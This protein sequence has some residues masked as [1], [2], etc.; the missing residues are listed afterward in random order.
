MQLYIAKGT[1]SIAAA[2]VLEEAGLAY[3]AIV[4]DFAT[5]AQT[6]PDYMAVNP[7][8]RVPALTVPDGILTETGAILEYIATLAPAAGLAP[9]DALNAARMRE[10]MYYIAST[11]HVN[12]AHKLRG[13]RWADLPESHADMRAKVAQTMAASCTYL[14]ENVAFSPFVLGPH[15]SL[16]DAYLYVACTWLE[17]DNVDIAAYPRLAAHF[18]AMGARPSVKKLRAYDWI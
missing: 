8:G 4:L 5:A 2:L 6:K 10:V 14:E 9:A 1:I 18:A 3:D 16:A 7:K 15:I 17:G 13:T 12:H 11:M